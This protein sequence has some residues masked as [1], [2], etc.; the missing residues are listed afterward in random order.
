[1]G[2]APHARWERAWNGTGAKPGPGLLGEIFLGYDEAHRAYHTR[3]HLDEC[4]AAFDEVRS[5]AEHPA[6]IEL[7][8]FFHD[9]FYDTRRS[10]NEERSA[11]WARDAL[12]EGG[13]DPL[14]AER[15]RALV[16]A[17]KTHAVEGAGDAALFVDVDLAILGAESARFD[18]YDQQI[19]QEYSWVPED[20]YRDGRRRVLE[21]FAERAH[22]FATPWFRDK[23]DA[24]AKANLRR[25][26]ERLG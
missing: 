5:L 24:R 6:E 17:S 14:V 9:V 3:R 23:L 15:V 13:G 26:L 25:A 20:A 12:I 4:F 18:E 1:M 16:L 10:D 11:E 7:A 2:H 19:R 22:V 8:V 21:G